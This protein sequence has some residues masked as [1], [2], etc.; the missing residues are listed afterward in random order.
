MSVV[1]P[2]VRQL[3]MLRIFCTNQ[4]SCAKLLPKPENFENCTGL[5][6]NSL[7]AR[8]LMLMSVSMGENANIS[9]GF[10]EQPQGDECFSGV[11]N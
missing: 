3:C 11:F 5:L 2:G 6:W 4:F 7:K 9:T 8:I 10:S 1:D